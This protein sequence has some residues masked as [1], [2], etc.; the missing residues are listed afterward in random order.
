MKKQIALFSILILAFASTALYI[1]RPVELKE[2]S[3]T[4]SEIQQLKITH[5]DAVR[6]YTKGL[7]SAAF[8]FR[9]LDFGDYS[10]SGKS[11]YI[12]CPD[13]YE[14]IDSELVDSLATL[15]VRVHGAKEN[16][17]Y[18]EL[19]RKG[20]ER[21]YPCNPVTRNRWAPEG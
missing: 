10:A 4:F 15:E 11:S 18:P 1:S 20:L 19:V 2:N 7:A 5:P 14:K 16:E 21:A 13:A 6:A 17:L 9:P 3:Y 8:V 12:Y